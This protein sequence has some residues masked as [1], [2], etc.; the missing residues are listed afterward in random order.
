MYF[1]DLVTW[2]AVGARTVE[3]QIHRQLASDMPFP[4]GFKNGTSGNMTVA[5]DAAVVAVGSHANISIDQHGEVILKRSLGNVA[6]HLVLRGGLAPNY[7]R[8]FIVEAQKH[9]DANNV[10]TGVL[11]DC[12]HANSSK[13]HRNQSRVIDYLLTQKLFNNMLRGFMIESN[14]SQD[15]KSRPIRF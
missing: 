1:A 14:L 13:D 2:G 3:S 5:I 6:P 15:I 9:L 7:Q 8:D 10:G 12:S 11:V 4:V